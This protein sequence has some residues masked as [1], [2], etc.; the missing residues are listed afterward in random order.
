MF[1]CLSLNALPLVVLSRCPLDPAYYPASCLMALSCVTLFLGNSCYVKLSLMVA[2][3]V[4]CNVVGYVTS[5]HVFYGDNTAT[6][7]VQAC[8]LYVNIL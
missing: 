4:A 7:S 1:Y 5:G 3:C 6:R 8:A 2:A